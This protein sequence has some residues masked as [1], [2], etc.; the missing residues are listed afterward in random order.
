MS[1]LQEIETVL[2]S[3]YDEIQVLCR[4]QSGDCGSVAK[5][6]QN[7]YGGT[8]IALYENPDTDRLP[9]HIAVKIDGL[10]YD[11][12]GMTDKTELYSFFIG[13]KQPNKDIPQNIDYY[14]KEGIENI[15]EVMI[16]DS[17]VR[18][19]EAILKRTKSELENSTVS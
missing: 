13:Y 2:N 5:A 6:I 17:I 15:H 12:E 10:L 14:Y 4:P 8:L 3:A 1:S 18:Q 19:V 9:K 16:T 7:I 11:N